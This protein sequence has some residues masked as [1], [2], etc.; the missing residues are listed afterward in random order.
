M[1]PTESSPRPE[2]FGEDVGNQLDSMIS[3]EHETHSLPSVRLWATFLIGRKQTKTAPNRPRPETATDAPP[4]RMGRPFF[5][6]PV[7]LTGSTLKPAGGT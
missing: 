3:V 2:R 4:E 1:P 5:F 6:A 7:G